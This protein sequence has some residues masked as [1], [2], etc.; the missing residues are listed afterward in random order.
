M[1]NKCV[2][3]DIDGTLL[4]SAFILNELLEK[5]LKGKAKWDYFYAH[6][7]SDKV[8]VVPC[9][10]EIIKELVI[11]GYVPILSTARN[12]HNRE[13]TIEKLHKEGII[14]KELYM[15]QDGDYR[16]SAEVKKE[17]LISISEKYDIKFFMDDDVSNINMAKELGIGTIQVP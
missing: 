4:K 6:C 16:P 15:R 11:K 5:N 8:K 12:E 10:R 14:F 17:H 1:K 9:M 13:A 7:N 3:F 2:V